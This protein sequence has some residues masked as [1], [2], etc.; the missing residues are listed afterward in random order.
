MC[1][2]LFYHFRRILDATYLNLNS[3]I[4]LNLFSARVMAVLFKEYLRNGIY[5]VRHLSN[6]LLNNFSV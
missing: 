4:L 1:L 6:M 3:F 5:E 2:Y